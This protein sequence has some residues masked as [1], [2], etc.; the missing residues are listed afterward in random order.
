FKSPVEAPDRTGGAGAE[1]LEHV[2]APE[3]QRILTGSACDNVFRFGARTGH[4]ST[5]QASD[6][7]LSI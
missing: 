4:C 1:I 6:L 7:K 2:A 3:F 5:S